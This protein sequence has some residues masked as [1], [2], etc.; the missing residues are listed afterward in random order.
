MIK[1]ARD[2]LVEEMRSDTDT[3]IAT[4]GRIYPQDIATLMN[5]AF[6]C[7]TVAFNGGV[8]DAYLSQLADASISIKVFS[9]KSYN[10]CWE[11]YEYIKTALAFGVFADADVRIR[12]T[13]STL[14]IERY[15]SIGRVFNVISGWDITIIGT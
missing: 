8:P 11:V 14:P 6:P 2:R 13:E 9:T 3:F 4:S 1:D 7:V 12:T 10:Q 5:P 15:D